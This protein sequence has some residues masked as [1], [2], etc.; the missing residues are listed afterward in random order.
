M[1]SKP[2]PT[3]AERARERICPECGGPVERKTPH[4]RFPTFCAKACKVEH[5]NRHI[6][7]GRAVIALLKAWRIDRG[8]GDIAKGAFAQVHQMVDYF[9]AE[10]LKAGRPRADLYAAKILAE[11]TVFFD[12]MANG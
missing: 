9:N 11:G 12:R 5:Y 3:I 2:L 10:D 1:A 6:R 7:E 4:G 8:A